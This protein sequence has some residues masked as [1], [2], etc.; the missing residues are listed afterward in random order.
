M[1][2]LILLAPNYGAFARKKMEKFIINHLFFSNHYL[3]S[4]FISNYIGFPRL[5]KSHNDFQQNSV[6][7]TVG[8]SS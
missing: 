3:L 4:S 2:F 6:P 7:K 8:K 1:K 5:I